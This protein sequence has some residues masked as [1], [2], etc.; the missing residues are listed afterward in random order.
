MA[1]SDLGEPAVHTLNSGWSGTT[2]QVPDN[3]TNGLYNEVRGLAGIRDIQQTSSV[4]QGYKGMD[5]GEDYEKVESARLLS[6][7]E[8]TL[9]SALGF[10]SLK[11]ALNQDEVLAVAYEYTY[12]GQVYQVG[13]F[14]TD[15]SEEQVLEGNA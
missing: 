1:F 2:Q 10:I 13:E 3:K 4:L 12:G 8:Y 15:G 7:S 6:S 5:G 11:Q 9:N 14:S